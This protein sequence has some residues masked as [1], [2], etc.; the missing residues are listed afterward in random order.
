MSGVHVHP[1][2]RNVLTKRLH[3]IDGIVGL[4]ISKTE[5]GIMLC[6]RMLFCLEPLGCV[7]ST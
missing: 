1:L 7:I 6:V 5:K 3:N 4:R 2:S